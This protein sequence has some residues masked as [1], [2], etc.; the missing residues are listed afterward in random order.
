MS[1]KGDAMM[2]SVANKAGLLA[3]A[4]VLSLMAGGA[5]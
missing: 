5:A 4:A 2:K 1:F 3:G